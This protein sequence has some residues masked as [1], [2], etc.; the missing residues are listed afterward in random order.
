MS[1]SL[2]ADLTPDELTIL[3]IVSTMAW[4]DGELSAEERDLLL[5]ELSQLFA[6]DEAETEGLYQTLQAHTQFSLAQ[7]PTL[8]AQL[9]AED[10]KVLALKLSYMTIRASGSETTSGIN[11][12]EKMAYRQLIELLGLPEALIEKTEWAADEDLQ[13]NGSFATAIRTRLGQFFGRR[14]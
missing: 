7:L 4:S 5:T 14:S 1:V 2:P 9:P 8:V 3:Q 6:E 11:V 12:K 13:K 10:D